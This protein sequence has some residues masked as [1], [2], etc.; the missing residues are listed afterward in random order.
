MSDW[1]IPP[2]PPHISF[3]EKI[4][5]LARLKKEEEEESRRKVERE[6]EEAKKREE[7][8]RKKVVSRLGRGSSIVDRSVRAELDT[9]Q[10]YG[11]AEKRNS[12]N[13]IYV[14]TSKSKRDTFLVGGPDIQG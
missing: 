8:N 4:N 5:R 9:I 7:S 6:A 2:P 14:K 10:R 11:N 13:D 3:L 12:L 1:L